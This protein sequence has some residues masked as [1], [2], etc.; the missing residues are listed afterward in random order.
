[1]GEARE[2][3]SLAFF[4]GVMGTGDEVREEGPEF[5]PPMP[6]LFDPGVPP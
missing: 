2:K 4:D 3:K 1:M 6:A 5:P